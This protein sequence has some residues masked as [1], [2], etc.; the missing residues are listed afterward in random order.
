MAGVAGM[1]VAIPREIDVQ[2]DFTTIL[3]EAG[4]R[5]TSVLP[6][7]IEF[8]NNL[9]THYLATEIVN[10]D[11]IVFSSR[12][13]VFYCYS[14]LYNMGMLNFLNKINIAAVGSETAKVIK[15]YGL[16]VKL[17]PKSD[18]NVAG[19]INEF[20]AKKIQDCKILLPGSN[21]A[22][23]VL[24][25]G[26]NKIGNDCI[27]MTVYNNNLRKKNI[28]SIK[29]FLLNDDIRYLAITSP[30]AIH[31]IVKV[32]EYYNCFESVRSK[33][34]SVIG[35]PSRLACSKYSLSVDI[36]PP[37]S[38]LKNLAISI[39]QYYVNLIK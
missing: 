15:N 9:S 34:I 6:Y 1:F 33:H 38:T 11:W 19:I 32:A 3:H 26:L 23:C 7:S 29:N 39:S 16:D 27:S 22:S 20:K 24:E 35:D 25:Q 10:S 28:R 13:S 2:H 4:L 8:N 30:S 18:F 12:Y 37:I 36:Q 31:N 5:V 14:M 21:L 17:L